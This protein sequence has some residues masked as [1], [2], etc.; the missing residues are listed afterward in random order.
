MTDAVG[1]LAKAGADLAQAIA[2]G[3]ADAIEHAV[4]TLD[5]AVAQVRSVDVWHADPA[6]SATLHALAASLSA[7]ARDVEKL[8]GA[9]RR[10]RFLIDALAG[11]GRVTAMNAHR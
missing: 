1:R 2:S 4:A 9:T 7:A 6:L 8:T 11:R 10:R 5:A 3:D